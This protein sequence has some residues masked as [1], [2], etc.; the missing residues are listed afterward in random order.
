MK[1]F[2]LNLQLLLTFEV[3]GDVVVFSD[4]DDGR[5]KKVSINQNIEY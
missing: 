5:A 1:Y 3:S 2:S 4:V